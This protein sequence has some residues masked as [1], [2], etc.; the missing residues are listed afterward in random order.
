MT[1]NC[2]SLGE[3]QLS[4]VDHS[5]GTS[6]VANKFNYKQA[7]FALELREIE[8]LSMLEVIL[9]IPLILLL[10]ACH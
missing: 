8:I 10:I 2:F 7:N 6:A 5:P 4:L 1:C 9:V 3:I